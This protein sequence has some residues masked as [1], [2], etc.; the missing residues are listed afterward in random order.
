M[1]SRFI[2]VFF[3]CSVALYISLVCFNNVFDY[4][5]QFQFAHM[6]AKMEDIFLKDK[7]GWRSVNNVSLHHFCFIIIILWE[8]SVAVLIWLGAFNMMSKFLADATE[9]KNAKKYT[10]LGLSLGVLLWFSVFIAIAGE[11]FLMWQSK[12]WN[13]QP[14]AFFIT[15]F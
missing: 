6:V 15:C 2:K 13:A 3:R 14:T 4:I 1:N 12:N 5:S 11:W 8:L 7:N 9:F 10:S